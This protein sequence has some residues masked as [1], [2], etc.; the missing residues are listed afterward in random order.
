[1]KRAN[2]SDLTAERLKQLLHYDP[3]TGI[4]VWRIGRQ[5][6]LA[7]AVAGVLRPDG[8]ILIGV[9]RE[10]HFAHRLAWLYMT[11]KFPAMDL[12]HEDLN[13]ANNRFVNLREATASQNQRN[14]RRPIHNTSGL[15]GVS[16]HNQRKRWMA[17]IK[18]KGRGIYL[19]LFDTKEEAHAAYCS[20]ATKAEPDFARFE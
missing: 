19:G 4:F 10:R 11:G 1:M 15:K 6:H 3:E 20:A 14:Q 2:D 18:I 13:P 17:Q 12:D 5:G 8:R 16:F 7:G 9:D